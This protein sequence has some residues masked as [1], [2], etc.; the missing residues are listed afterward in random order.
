MERQINQ[1]TPEKFS[2]DPRENLHLENQ[3]IKLKLQAESGTVVETGEE[4]PPELENV[5]LQ[6][7]MAFEEA[8]KDVSMV[9]VYD[10]LG[11]PEYR[12]I[13]TLRPE[14]IGP[15]L[16]RLMHL[17]QQRELVLDVL[18]NYDPA[19][20]YR[21]ITEEL[22]V[23]ETYETLLPGM[24]RHFSYE[25]FHPNHKLDIRERTMDFLG[26]WF[27]RK[28]DDTSWE[29]STEFILPDATKMKRED[30][31]NKFKTIFA[32]YTRFINCQ[33]VI[34]DISFEWNEAGQTGLGY[35]EGAVK[36]EAV[37]ESGE[38]VPM[39]GP[40]KLYFSNQAGWWSIFYFIFP[41]FTWQDEQ[42]QQQQ[43]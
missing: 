30:V 28:M 33:Y 41:G 37:L 27:E 15:E 34:G 23:Q 13:D 35:S 22:F 24:I 40:F 32:S 4:V 1:E 20:I 9:T 6:N 7:V 38:I 3:F 11:R 12:P 10:F 8:S 18:D 5:F 43:S 42:Q 31:V 16:K 36:F 17:L 39:E 19:V 21:F 25:E 14:E 26:D 29:L 2:D